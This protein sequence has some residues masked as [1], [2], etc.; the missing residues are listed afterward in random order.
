MVSVTRY[1][2]RRGALLVDV[3][4]GV[5][6]LGV[7]LA[8]MIGLSARAVSAQRAGENLQIA[9]MLIDERLNMVLATGPEDYATAF[10]SLEGP[11]DE[12]YARFRYALSI[13]EGTA[14]QPFRVSCTVTWDESGKP[15]SETVRT[16]IAPRLGDEPDPDRKP[17]E[18]TDRLAGVLP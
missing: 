13:Q 18:T 1:S 2:S 11:C 15:H 16:L 4:V 7:A 8:V 14:G 12:P 3:L 9:A 17:P 6:M 10:G 5:V